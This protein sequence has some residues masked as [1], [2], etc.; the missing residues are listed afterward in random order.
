MVLGEAAGVGVEVL[1]VP[2]LELQHHSRVCVEGGDSRSHAA[3]EGNPGRAR[4]KHRE[5][6]V[7]V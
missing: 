2:T 3:G 1:P 7:R 5:G 6:T 4:G